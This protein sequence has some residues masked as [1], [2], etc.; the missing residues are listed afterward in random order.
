MPENHSKDEDVDECCSK[1]GQVPAVDCLCRNRV[2]VFCRRR[3]VRENGLSGA[4]GIAPG[5]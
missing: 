2:V 4:W 5:Q 1:V 3:S